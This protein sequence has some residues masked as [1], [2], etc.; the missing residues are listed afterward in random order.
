[1]KNLKLS[2]FIDDNKDKTTSEELKKQCD[3]IRKMEDSID[4]DRSLGTKIKVKTLSTAKVVQEHTLVE[5]FGKAEVRK[6]EGT[7]IVYG[8]TFLGI[9]AVHVRS[10]D[11]NQRAF[12]Q[13]SCPTG[14]NCFLAD[15]TDFAGGVIYWSAVG[16]VITA[17]KEHI[18]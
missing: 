18:V 3:F 6:G 10:E 4:E 15:D 9:P 5:V 2:Q 17:H 16:R 1:M 13:G 12:V 7:C 11:S 8:P 14:F